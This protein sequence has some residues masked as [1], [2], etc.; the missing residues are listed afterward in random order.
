M[1]ENYSTVWRLQEVC[2]VLFKVESGRVFFS[3]GLKSA[4]REVM[5]VGLASFA[6]Y[7]AFKTWARYRFRQ[8]G[9]IIILAIQLRRPSWYASTIFFTWNSS[10]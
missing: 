7:W 8:T 10:V 3:A 6:W 4:M 2:G 5:M 9:L 1:L